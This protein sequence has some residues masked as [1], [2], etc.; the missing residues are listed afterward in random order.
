[1]INRFEKEYFFLSNFYEHPIEENGIIYP[2]N[3]HYFQ[4]MKTLNIAERKKIAAAPTP[5]EA[6]RMGRSVSLRPDWEEIKLDVMKRGL[7]LKFAD[8]ALAEK[9]LDTLDEELVEGNWWHDNIW[10]NCNCDKCKNI[11]GQNNLGK[12]LM[13]IRAELI[14]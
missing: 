2:T 6:K 14:L 5:G 9:L 8:L 10:G 12:L 1:M 3:E 13:K 4:A 7:R 11:K